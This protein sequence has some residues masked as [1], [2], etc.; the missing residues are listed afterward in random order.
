MK[1]ITKFMVAALAVAAAGAAAVHTIE[2]H[3][4]STQ[5]GASSKRRARFEDLCR[6]A[7]SPGSV[8]RSALPGSR[9]AAGC[10]RWYYARARALAAHLPG[11]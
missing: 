11:P 2:A 5:R 4:V 9:C 6:L 8:L 7:G 3:V 1:T 10:D